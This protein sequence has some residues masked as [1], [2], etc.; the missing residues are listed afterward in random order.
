[1]SDTKETI[2]FGVVG[3]GHF[4]QVAVLPA[5]HQLQDVK[6]AA[7]VSGS[8]EKL[9]TLGD[10]YDVPHRSGY[11]DLEALLAS[12]ELDAV[13]VAT[14]NDRHAEHTIMTAQHG[15]HVLCEKP[16]APSARECERMIEAAEEND[17]R[18]MIAY[19]LHFESGNL[20][21][22]DAI[23]QGRIGS[24]RLFNSVFTLQVRPE[25][26]RIQAR[27]G[28]GPLYDIGTYC[29]NAARY[30]FR[31]E[32]TEVIAQMASKGDDERFRFAEETVAATLRFSDE[33]LANFVV[34]FGAYGTAEYKVVGTE[35]SLSLDCAYE[36][37]DDIHLTVKT[38][39]GATRRKFPQRDQIAA[40]VSYF[41]DCVRSGADPEPSGY[42]GLADVRVIEAIRASAERGERVAI[43]PVSQ[44]ARPTLG[45]ARRFPAHDKPDTVGVES[46]SLPG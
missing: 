4:A 29:I 26:T 36:Y 1:M 34:S 13:Y 41:A 31:G 38:R 8:A 46:G 5:L 33:R 30:L 2:R 18:L 11:E 15:V 24:P 9:A 7:L 17:I 39:D 27:A 20:S 19:R 21:S 45:Q 3:L 10:R 35:G 23:E 42:E 16:M 37:V 12:G 43:E 28:A 25:N 40:E 14:P 6:I 22:I 44:S 32:P